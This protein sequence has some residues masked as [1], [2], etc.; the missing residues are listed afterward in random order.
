MNDF[1]AYDSLASR[2]SNR[3][4]Y[5][6]GNTILFAQ[7]DRKHGVHQTPLAYQSIIEI[8]PLCNLYT[9]IRTTGRKTKIVKSLCSLLLGSLLANG[10]VEQGFI[11]EY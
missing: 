8:Y 7:N 6:H 4:L 3:L 5:I 1:S 9:G 2:G 11:N 10:V